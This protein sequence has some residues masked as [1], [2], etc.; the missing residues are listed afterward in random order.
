MS[1]DNYDGWKVIDTVANDIEFSMI[2][3]LLKSAEIPAIRRIHGANDFLEI[4]IGTPLTGIDVLVPEDKYDEAVKLLEAPP[5][6]DEQ[7]IEE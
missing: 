3:A 1:K 6:A 2:E 5:L 7:Y 4:I